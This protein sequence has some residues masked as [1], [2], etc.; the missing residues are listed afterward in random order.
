MFLIFSINVIIKRADWFSLGNTLIKT[1][2]PN[3]ISDFFR[4]KYRNQKN[5]QTLTFLTNI[6]EEGKGKGFSHI[7]NLFP[8]QVIAF[9]CCVLTVFL[10]LGA[11]STADWMMAEGWREGLFV[12]CVSEGAHRPL[13][14]EIPAEVGCSKARSASKFKSSESIIYVFIGW[15]TKVGWGGGF[16]P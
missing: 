7:T 12:Q 13:P 14:F 1:L 8:I 10:M 9:T 3:K 6:S 4:P 2:R 16:R 5:S 11:T 15:T